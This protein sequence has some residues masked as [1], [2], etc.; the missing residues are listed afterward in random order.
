MPFV[1]VRV[2]RKLARTWVARHEK[3][4]LDEWKIST[5]IRSQYLLGSFERA[6]PE[7]QCSV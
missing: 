2:P 6:E 4:G 1:I 3:D 5:F 7:V